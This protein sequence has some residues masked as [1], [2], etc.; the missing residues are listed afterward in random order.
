MTSGIYRRTKPIWNKGLTKDTSESV[1]NIGESFKLSWSKKSE[2][3]KLKSNSGM[4]KKGNI[5]WNE[6]LTKDTNESL[7]NMSENMSGE[8]NPNFG[9]TMP[10]ETRDI[11]SQKMSGENNPFFGHTHTLEVKEKQSQSMSGENHPCWGKS[12]AMKGRR[13]KNHPSYGHLPSDKVGYGIGSW[14]YT[15][16]QGYKYL[17]SSYEIKYAEYLDQ[18]NIK[19]YYEIKTFSIT[20][21]INNIIKDTTYTPDFYLS[22][23]NKFIEI[24]GYLD[25][26]PKL[27]IEKF[28]ELYSY[29]LNVL[30][31][32]DLIKLGIN[33]KYY[34]KNKFNKPIQD[35]ISYESSLSKLFEENHE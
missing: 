1:K 29:N 33:L 22:E 9:K 11:I 3:E 26:E 32:K 13:G 21:N 17:R 5:S 6:G 34:K 30:F 4:F 27:K 12:S 20:I 24:K 35:E 18:H 15:P 2:E 23:Y 28:Y 31:E 7:Q 10:Q 8:N 14:Y 16:C 25:E 19:W